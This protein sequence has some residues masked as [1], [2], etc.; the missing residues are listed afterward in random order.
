[1]IFRGS[2]KFLVSLPANCCPRW[3]PPFC[4]SHLDHR[5]EAVS[6]FRLGIRDENGASHRVGSQTVATMAG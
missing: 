6:E 4:I 5:L 3:L 1:M 2:R